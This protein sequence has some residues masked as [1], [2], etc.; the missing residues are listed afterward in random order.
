MQHIWYVA[1]GSNL[2]RERF[3]TYLQGGQP[4]GSERN[5]S[6]VPGHQRRGRQFRLADHRRCLL[7]R[8]VLGLEGRDG[9]L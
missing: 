7:R 9:V 4:N 1:Y 2:S 6:R 8:S 5:I 3:C